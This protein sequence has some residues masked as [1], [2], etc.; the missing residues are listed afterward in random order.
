MRGRAWLNSEVAALPRAQGGL[1]IP[2]LKVE[3][4][5]LAAVTVNHWAVD[6]SPN[7]QVVGDVLAGS[8]SSCDAP[9]V[10]V[11]PRHTIPSAQGK[12]L[13]DTLWGTGVLVCNAFGGVAPTPAK[14]KMVAA[15]SCILYFRGPLVTKWNGRRLGVNTH[16]LQGSVCRMYTSVESAAYGHFCSEVIARY[17]E[18][19]AALV[20]DAVERLTARCWS[21]GAAIYLHAVWRWRVA[22]FDPLNDV[23][24][25]FRLAGLANRLRMGHQDVTRDITGGADAALRRQISSTLRGARGAPAVV[26]SSTVI[27]RVHLLSGTFETQYITSTLHEGRGLTARKAAQLGLLRG[28]RHCM[29]KSWGPVHVVGDDTEL[30][31][32]QTSRRPPRA[33]TLRDTFW[34]IRRTADATAVVSWAQQH[35]D[36]N[37]TADGF[38]RLTRTTERSMEWYAAIPQQSTTK[39]AYIA[40]RL[41]EDV[42][43][44][45]AVREAPSSSEGAEGP[46]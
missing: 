1:A 42:A 20:G 43:Q 36:Q 4:L 27:V 14:A 23:S 39:W 10:Y 21:L 12:R 17:P 35:R 46:V 15:L 44:W 5:A 38:M 22:H 8:A 26:T 2:D 19:Q 31:R 3:L 28:L 13:R 7:L 6:A 25:E 29:H 30:L 24:Q 34:K 37:R 32:Q 9:M 41:Q 11:T 16:G 45:I 33:A 40:D 18:E